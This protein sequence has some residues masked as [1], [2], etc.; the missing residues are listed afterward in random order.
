MAVMVDRAPS[1]KLRAG[2][3]LAW[4]ATLGVAGVLTIVGARGFTLYEEDEQGW[5]LAAMGVLPAMAAVVSLG[6]GFGERATWALATVAAWLA[7]FHAYFDYM[8]HPWWAGPETF[9]CDG[10]CFG[11]YAFENPPLVKL[12][13]IVG[14]LSVAAGLALHRLLAL[15]R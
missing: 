6:R 4:A 9:T 1:V 11:W 8:N 3:A 2:A 10:P 13:L 12:H 14:C 5:F 7:I 15:K